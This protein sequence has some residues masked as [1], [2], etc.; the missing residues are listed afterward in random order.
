VLSEVVTVPIHDWTFVDAGIFHHFHHEWIT[1]LNHA[2]NRRLRGTE[3][4]A[5]AE[6]IAGG[7]VPDVLTLQLQ[8]GRA[9]KRKATQEVESALALAEAPP[10]VRFRITRPDKWYAAKKKSV[11]IHH[12]SNHRVVAVLE[13]ISAGNKSSRGEIDAFIR[14]S[15]AL[16]AAG[17]HLQLVDLF[18]PGPR[19]PEGIHP[20]VWDYDD[21]GDFRFDPAK[22]LTCASY[23][24]QPVPEAFVEPVAV[25]DQLP[26]MPLFLNPDEYIPVELEQ[27][28]QAAFEGVP[29]FWKE[30]LEQKPRSGKR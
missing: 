23:R 20:L 17:V 14:K 9:P 5:L 29:D 22:P 3:Y 11:T 6:Q 13:I 24:A 15:Q 1:T 10:K 25:G 4:Y 19:D 16:L 27:S 26:A 2:V 18:P 28:Y 12:V 7:V 30:M 21:P 8:A